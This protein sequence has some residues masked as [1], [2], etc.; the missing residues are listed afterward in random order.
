MQ[1]VIAWLDDYIAAFPNRKRS[2]HYQGIIALRERVAQ[3]AETDEEVR[4][5]SNCGSTETSE[6]HDERQSITI[7][8]VCGNDEP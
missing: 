1:T 7:C 5:C 6:I 2:E 4:E 3:V 8:A